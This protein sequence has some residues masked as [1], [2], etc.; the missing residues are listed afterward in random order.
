MANPKYEI[1]DGFDLQKL[2]DKWYTQAL[3]NEARDFNQ[4]LKDKKA[5]FAP[6]LKK[7]GVDVSKVKEIRPAELK[8]VLYGAMQNLSQHILSTV[9][10][11]DCGGAFNYLKNTPKKDNAVEL[12][13]DLLSEIDPATLESRPDIK[14]REQLYEKHKRLF[15]ARRGSAATE[16]IDLEA[17]AA[18]YEQ[19]L[20]A[21]AMEGNAV[22]DKLVNKV[23][24]DALY[25]MTLHLVLN[26]ATSSLSYDG[27]RDK[28]KET[29]IGD[30][31]QYLK[32]IHN[33]YDSDT[34]ASLGLGIS[35]GAATLEGI[36]D[37]AS[38]SKIKRQL[39][40]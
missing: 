29:S 16:K 11:E 33:G 26:Q 10:H 14:E 34:R 6:V 13:I 20:N 12:S 24:A 17:R 3:S 19:A 30:F 28:L 5:Q 32:Y 39:G 9:Q 8:Q 2:F 18:E 38:I 15:N 27:E 35:I 31:A 25:Y 7:F 21:K 22:S 4:F 36:L 37:K 1:F 23:I 40:I